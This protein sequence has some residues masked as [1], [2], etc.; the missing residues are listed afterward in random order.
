LE[1][2]EKL[3]DDKYLQRWLGEPVKVLIIPTK[4]YQTNQR[5]YPVLSKA[6][7]KFIQKLMRFPSMHLIVTGNTEKHFVGEKSY[8]EYLRFLQKNLSPLDP[9]E[10]ASLSYND[11]LQA[12]LQPLMDNLE[13]QVYEVFEK[14]PVKYQQ[15]E[16]AV[17]KALMERFNNV[18]RTPV[19]MVLG[20]GRGPLVK[21]SLRASERAKKPIKV[22]AVEKNQN[23]VITLQNL[24]LDEW[25]EKVT[26]VFGDMREWKAPEKAD[27]IVSELLGSFGD[28]ELSPEC[29]DGAQHFLR[30]D[31]I[32]IPCS[33]TSYI[34]PISSQKLFNEVKSFNDLK[35]FET[36]F[37][38]KFQNGWLMSEIKPLFTFNHPNFE[39]DGKGEIDNSRFGTIEFV[40]KQAGTIHG[41]AGYF[42]SKLYSDVMLSIHPQTH[43]EGMFSWFPIF[44]PLRSP[45]YVQAG[46]KVKLSFWRKGF[47]KKV[48]YE[49][50][51]VSP[52]VMPIHNSNGRSYSI[53]L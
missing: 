21:A 8:V 7:Q 14:D 17:H 12:P 15:Y 16:E 10:A 29:L 30:E 48:W 11:Y 44:F 6:H 24:K 31:G 46:S 26:V 23:A 20:A 51:L 4:I 32:S 40:I 43:S 25:G 2:P 1:L 13:S 28:N 27:I 45:T 50:T 22:Y 5:D 41:I 39:T 36:P 52:C 3:P 19:I 42:D 35:H 33:Y 47:S 53:G 18:D 38:V 37:V 49:W 9:K 34:C